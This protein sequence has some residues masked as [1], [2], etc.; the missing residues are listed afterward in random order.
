MHIKIAERLRPFSHNPGATLILPGSGYRLQVFPALLKVDDLSG[1]NPVAVSEVAF[2]LSGPIRDFTVEQDLEKGRVGIWGHA[3]EGYFRYWITAHADGNGLEIAFDKMP[4]NGK[5]RAGDRLTLPSQQ[6]QDS[7]FLMPKIDRLS[8][9]SNKAQD[10][11]MVCRRRDFAEI[12]PVWHRLGQLVPSSDSFDEVGTL[13]LLQ[14][15]REAIAAKAPEHILKSFE[16]LYLSGFEGMLS[17]RLQDTDHQGIAVQAIPREACSSPLELLSRGSAVI[18]SLFVQHREQTIYLL[19][20][21]PTE[22]HCGRLIDVACGD[23]GSLSIEWTKRNMRCA[24]FAAENTQQ[25]SFVFCNRE[26]RCRLRLNHKDRGVLYFSGKPLA[27]AAG[28]NYWF[29]NFEN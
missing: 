14:E 17:P 7:V 6:N 15:C 11:E 10:W 28:Q 1:H 8:L 13:T 5:F 21:L 4:G 29:D 26:K 9:G 22:F 24:S 19:P 2:D 23:A 12:F 25:L 18:R 3:I 16:R 27:V 20:A